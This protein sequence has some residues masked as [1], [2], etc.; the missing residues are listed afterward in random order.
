M[1]ATEVLIVGAGPVGL[2]LGCLLKMQG[3]DCVIIEQRAEPSPF[4]K[5]FGLHARTVELLELL[6]LGEHVR[7]HAVAVQKMNIFANGKPMLNFDFS[8]LGELGLNHVYSFPQNQLESILRAK[9][10]KLGGKVNFDYQ[11]SSFS[12][13]QGSVHGELCISQNQCVPFSASY[14]VGCDG[15]HSTVRKLS[16]IPFVGEH[17]DESFIVIDGELNTSILRQDIDPSQG[18]TFVNHVGYLM[19]FPLPGGLHRVVINGPKASLSNNDL[20]PGELERRF[21][22]LGFSD[23]R[24]TSYQWISQA[25]LKAKIAQNYVKGR[26]LLAGD[27]CHVHSPVGG[28]GVNLGIQDSF[29]LAWKLVQQLKQDAPISSLLDYEL[30][31]K[32][33]AHKV[34]KNT[35][36]LHNLLSKQDLPRRLLRR[37]VVPLLNRSDKFKHQLVLDAS[38][39]A[40]SYQNAIK[41][42][43]KL[44]TFGMRLPNIKV[45]CDQQDNYLYQHLAVNQLTRISFGKCPPKSSSHNK[46]F[47]YRELVVSL[48]KEGHLETDLHIDPDVFHRQFKVMGVNENDQIVVRPDGYISS[49]INLTTEQ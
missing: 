22:L 32:P 30:E 18:Y 12:Q 21:N 23:V 47:S 1:I 43:N 39:Y 8:L 35:D 10:Q 38:G 33:I 41:P 25:S 48:T 24:F 31:R 34:I 40:H 20:L 44:L 36:K 29:N 9:Y 6:D 11:L 4:S 19:L 13:D 46:P 27:A 2:T 37:L 42:S 3:I 5:A 16:K 15:L 26:V 49:V 7:K 17:Y 28:Q 45:L 14:L